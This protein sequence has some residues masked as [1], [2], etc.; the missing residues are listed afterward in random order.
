MQESAEWLH[1]V[2]NRDFLVSGGLTTPELVVTM[3]MVDPN[4]VVKRLERASYSS[5]ACV[6]LA[7]GYV[8]AVLP[9]V[10]R[11]VTLCAVRSS[12]QQHAQRV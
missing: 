4:H 12:C 10:P 3:R 9:C 6:A 5:S 7:D 2:E 8:C 1:I 11:C